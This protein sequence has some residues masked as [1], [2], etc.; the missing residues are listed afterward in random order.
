MELL[1]EDERQMEALGGR[2]CSKIMV[3][4]NR[5]EA[6]DLQY[7]SGWFLEKNLE[8]VVPIR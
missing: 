7:P 4:R 3:W 2:N 1:V 8:A 5:L 6:L